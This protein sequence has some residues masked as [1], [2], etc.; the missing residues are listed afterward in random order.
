MKTKSNE[1]FFSN[2]SNTTLPTFMGFDNIKNKR[3]SCHIIENYIVQLVG[4]T[5]AVSKVKENITRTDVPIFVN[6]FFIFSPASTVK[7]YEIKITIL[8]VYDRLESI[9][10]FLNVSRTMT[11]ESLFT[12]LNTKQ[13]VIVTF[14][15]LLELI[16]LKLVRVEQTDHF[17][18]I[19]LYLNSEREEQQEA[20]RLYRESANA[21]SEI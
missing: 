6:K 13:E 19:R 17:E 20:I 8:S 12:V 16:R 7:P 18:T 11:F 15:A 2:H 1:I 4:A 9:L 10:E 3:I 5:T 21:E 14:L